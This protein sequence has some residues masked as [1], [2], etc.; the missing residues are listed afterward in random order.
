MEHSYN[1][2][3]GSDSIMVV[4]G[5]VEIVKAFDKLG[6]DIA[7]SAWNRSKIIVRKTNGVRNHLRL[8]VDKCIDEF[9][10]KRNTKLIK[11]DK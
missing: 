10:E 11:D 5:K 2:A 7:I 1:F 4:D 3:N 8:R 6:S 9:H